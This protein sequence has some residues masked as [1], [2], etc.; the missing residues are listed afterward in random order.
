MQGSGPLSGPACCPNIPGSRTMGDTI[1]SKHLSP[2]DQVMAELKNSQRV[3][4][5]ATYNQIS[6]TATVAGATGGGQTKLPTR[7]V[8][9]AAFVQ[10]LRIVTA[11][12]AILK[13]GTRGNQKAAADAVERIV[14]DQTG[15]STLNNAA[16]F[17]HV[18]PAAL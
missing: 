9:K 14:N 2:R 7:A 11:E 5:K 1:A 3:T 18:D 10:S 13:K 4:Y 16:A 6:P 17:A 8:E 15:T 12:L